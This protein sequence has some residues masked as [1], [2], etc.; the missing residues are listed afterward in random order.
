ML[1]LY[2]RSMKLIC[3]LFIR[4]PQFWALKMPRKCLITISTCYFDRATKVNNRPS[5]TL[6]SEWLQCSTFGMHKKCLWKTISFSKSVWNEHHQCNRNQFKYSR[7]Q[8]FYL[9]FGWVLLK[10]LKLSLLKN[11]SPHILD[12]WFCDLNEIIFIWNYL[13]INIH[14][15]I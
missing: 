10:I 3:I 11:K 9:F 14:I 12:K 1:I 4:S 6:R 5:A 8:T 2:P 13:H 7:H 15:L